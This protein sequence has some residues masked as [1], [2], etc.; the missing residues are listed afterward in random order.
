MHESW[1]FE[2]APAFKEVP[3]KFWEISAFPKAGR[4]CR[5]KKRTINEDMMDSLVNGGINIRLGV[6]RVKEK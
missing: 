5:A 4:N 2:H 3:R 6:V 1:I